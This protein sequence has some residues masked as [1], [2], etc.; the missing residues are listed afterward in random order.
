MKEIYCFLNIFK[1]IDNVLL[2]DCLNKN[3][4][5]KYCIMLKEENGE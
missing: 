4:K 5:I 2:I 3:H 1:N